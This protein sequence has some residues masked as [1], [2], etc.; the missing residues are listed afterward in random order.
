MM[1]TVKQKERKRIS[2]SRILD[3]AV[4]L[5]AKEGY[6]NCS[7][8]R[9]AKEAGVS[10]GLLYYHFKNKDEILLSIIESGLERLKAGYDSDKLSGNALAD[11]A[12][13]LDRYAIRFQNERDFWFVYSSITF[14]PKVSLESLKDLENEYS[15]L[16]NSFLI[17][18]FE[19]L[20]IENPVAEAFFLDSSL[21]GLTMHTC[22]MKD[23]TV[24]NYGIDLLK[25]KYGI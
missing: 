3:G 5:F 1:T 15:K 2:R 4:K 25:R 21:Y 24:L 19:Q 22:K 11:I 23:D 9:I 8:T 17:K 18:L 20:G 7:T 16:Q 6:A 14:D 13:F 10:Y 12:D